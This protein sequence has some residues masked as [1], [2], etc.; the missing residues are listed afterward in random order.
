VNNIV[1]GEFP[2][3][4]GSSLGR[5]TV[6]KPGAPNLSFPSHIP[7]RRRSTLRPMN[8]KEGRQDV[9]QNDLVQKFPE[10]STQPT[11]GCVSMGRVTRTKRTETDLPEADAIRLAQLGDA[12]AFERLYRLHSRRVYC[13][14]LR[15]VGNATE[16]E[17]LTQEVFLQ[18]F[19][20][21]ATF[22]SESAFFTWLYR[23]SKNVVLMKLRRKSGTETSLEEFTEPDE[24]ARGP[25]HDFHAPDLRL[26][27]L[28]DRLNLQRAVDQLPPG[29][30]AVFV[31]HE[32]LGYEHNEIA[33]IMDRSI[34]NSKSQL[35]KARTRLRELLG[36]RLSH[37]RCEISCELA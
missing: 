12:R 25:R 21:I 17:D 28:I 36:V 31:L 22:R 13:L 20:K 8:N 24:E 18:L 2:S 4:C 5:A 29:Y 26:T 7:R 34:G 19:R 10:T 32:I 3:H 11:D 6:A 1:H 33:K 35:H 27:A 37:A 16:A 14:C 9:P 15:M 30:R 23:L